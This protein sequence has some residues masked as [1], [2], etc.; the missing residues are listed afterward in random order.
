MRCG[1]LAGMLD[2]RV[3]PMDADT[4]ARS[5]ATLDLDVLIDVAGLEA[6]TARSSRGDR[7]ASSGR[8][9]KRK[10][11][12][13]DAVVRS[14]I[15]RE[16]R[17]ARRRIGATSTRALPGLRTTR[18]GAAEL[19][20]LWEDA[21]HAHQRGDVDGGTRRLFERAR[22]AARQRAGAVSGRHVRARRR[23][24]RNRRAAISRSRSTARRDSSMR[25]RRWHASRRLRATPTKRRRWRAKASRRCP[26]PRYCGA[27]S[28]RRNKV[29]EVREAAAAA[30][31][32]ALQRDPTH[33]E[34]HYNHGVA[35]QKTRNVA[36]AARAYQ[37]ALAFAPDLYAADF[38]L[39]VIFDQ[40]GNANAAI[41]AF[42]NVLSP[43]AGSCRCVQ[44]AGRDAAGRGLDRQVVCQLRAFRD[45]T[46]RT[47]SPSRRTHSKCA[48]TAPTSRDSADTSTACVTSGS[49]RASRW[50]CSM[51]SSR[52]S[53]C[54]IFSTS[55]PNSSAA[56][57]ARTTR[58]RVAFTASRG[59]DRRSACRAR[60]ASAICRAISAI[61]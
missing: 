29:A 16:A 10:P 32:E 45:V 52:S 46:A 11:A 48:R 30:F 37:R 17:A 6:P 57:D 31:A 14:D 49:P 43:G 38:N 47:T 36:E 53:T 60:F 13:N 18:V 50:K 56:S 39:G 3:L 5:I 26:S 2:L 8:F 25:V 61:T 12:R 20:T 21:V 55:S 35:L 15:R 7:R 42:S 28:A 27:R 51:H 24:H 54:C 33:G 40:Q 1:P 44:G 58:W 19:A 23:R 41:A 34:T 4:A 22:R 59:R 9:G